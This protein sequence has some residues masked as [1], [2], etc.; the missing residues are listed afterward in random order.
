MR[1]EALHALLV[2]SEDARCQHG[3]GWAA[4]ERLRRYIEEA[5]QVGP[6]R[7]EYE[8]WICAEL[9]PAQSERADETLGDRLGACGERSRQQEDRVDAAH[10]G[11]DRDRFGPRRRD[12]HECRATGARAG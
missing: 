10:L 12:L 4:G 5:L 1:A 6:V 3:L 8:T 2:G 11:V 9:P 7:R